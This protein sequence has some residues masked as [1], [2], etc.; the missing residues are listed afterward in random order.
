MDTHLVKTFSGTNRGLLPRIIY[1][2][3]GPRKGGK[4]EKAGKNN[5]KNEE[6]PQKEKNM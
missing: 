4:G 5:R 6:F 2:P 1:H 3:N